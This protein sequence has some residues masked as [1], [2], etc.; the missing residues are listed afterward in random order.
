MNEL[1]WIPKKYRERVASLESES[2]L[3]EDCKYMLYFADGWQ[4]TDGGNSVPVKS[5]KEALQYIK[6]A[7]PTEP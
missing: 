7:V 6:S 1:N 3:V 2:G 4:Y 5:K